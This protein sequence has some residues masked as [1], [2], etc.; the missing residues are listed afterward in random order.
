MT[1]ISGPPWMPGKMAELTAF[2]N[3]AFI[4]MTPP[5]GPRSDLCVVEVTKSACGTGLG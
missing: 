5:R 2:S 3:S 1:C 4:M